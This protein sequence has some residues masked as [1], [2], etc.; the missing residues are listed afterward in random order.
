LVANASVVR[1]VVGSGG[2][3]LA[4]TA[5]ALVREL[6]G[7][8]PTPLHT[9]TIVASAERG[10]P[11]WDSIAIAVGGVFALVLGVLVLVRRRARGKR[12]DPVP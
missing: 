12:P 9:T 7:T 3:G 8:A 2:D 4:R 11:V 6:T 1:A 10:F 5:I